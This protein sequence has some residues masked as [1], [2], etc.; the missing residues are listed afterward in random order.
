MKLARSA[1]PQAPVETIHL[2]FGMSEPL[3]ELA[4]LQMYSAPTLSLSVGSSQFCESMILEKQN[5]SAVIELPVTTQRDG[6]AVAAH[7]ETHSPNDKPLN[8]VMPIAIDFI[9]CPG[10]FWR[11]KEIKITPLI[12]LHNKTSVKLHVK[13]QDTNYVR[14]ENEEKSFY[15]LFCHL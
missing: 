5:G 15:L 10:K 4:P 8:R 6:I 7:S 9:P 11:T 13:Q 3:S 2:A 14:K 12:V 1:S